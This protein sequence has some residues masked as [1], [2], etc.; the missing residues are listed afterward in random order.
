MLPGSPSARIL[1]PFC[2]ALSRGRDSEVA[3]DGRGRNTFT[4]ISHLLRTAEQNGHFITGRAI[5]S[6]VRITNDTVLQEALTRLTNLALL[7][8]M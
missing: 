1:G 8:W 4:P 7:P 3:V 2:S 5:C 6:I